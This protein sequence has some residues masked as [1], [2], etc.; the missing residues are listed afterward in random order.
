MIQLNYKNEND[1]VLFTKHVTGDVKVTDII[2]D[3][4]EN[5]WV[6]MN[7][8][9]I[10]LLDNIE[11][12]DIGDSKIR[13]LYSFSIDEL[14]P[15]SENSFSNFEEILE[16]NLNNNAEVICNILNKKEISIIWG[17]PD[18][19]ETQSELK[20]DYYI[21]NE[22]SF[23]LLSM[24]VTP[25]ELTDDFKVRDLVSNAD[26]ISEVLKQIIYSIMKTEKQ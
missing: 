16:L 22:Y 26:K 7:I 9:E 10:D 20:L 8:R 11:F 2:K 23:V 13:I 5:L 17:G 21:D 4:T 24:D 6:S 19:P 3:Q 18:A 15:S 1:I 12:M 25:N 14:I